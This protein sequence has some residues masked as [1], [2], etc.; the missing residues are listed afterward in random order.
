MQIEEDQKI[1][2]STLGNCINDIFQE[3]YSCN[4]PV[5]AMRSMP[6]FDKRCVYVMIGKVE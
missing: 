2:I 4:L 1:E 5:S 3:N 6:N